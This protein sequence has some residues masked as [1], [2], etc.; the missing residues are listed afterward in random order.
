M[1]QD[2]L[3]CYRKYFDNIFKKDFIRFNHF[4]IVS[5][6]LFI[7]KLKNKLRFYVN[8]R[9]LN[10]MTIKNRYSISLIREILHCLI[11]V[12]IYI[13][14]NII[15]VYNILQMTFKEK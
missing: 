7:K 15:V 10:I 5:F 12:K 2:E 9:N 11:K 4:S 1:F 3:F 6:M 14:F 8:Y 13:K